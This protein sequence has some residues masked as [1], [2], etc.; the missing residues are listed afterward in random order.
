M[1]R[2]GIKESLQIT[3]EENYVLLNNIHLIKD[4]QVDTLNLTSKRVLFQIL[5]NCY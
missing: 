2:S 1:D 3:A 5:V 4:P